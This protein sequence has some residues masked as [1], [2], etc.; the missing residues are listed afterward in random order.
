MRVGRS[1]TVEVDVVAVLH[2]HFRSNFD[3]FTLLLTGNMAGD[4]VVL[5]ESGAGNVARKQSI[6]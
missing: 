6:T 5:M 1:R 2:L 4:K 3:R